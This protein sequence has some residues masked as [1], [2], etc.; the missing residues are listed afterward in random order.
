MIREIFQQ[1]SNTQSPRQKATMTALVEE[2]RKDQAGVHDTSVRYPQA[3]RTLALQALAILAQPGHF[4]QS[5]ECFSSWGPSLAWAVRRFNRTI[6]A[7]GCPYC[8]I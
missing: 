8:L 7:R 6:R 5:V 2:Y 1:R 3:G 4:I